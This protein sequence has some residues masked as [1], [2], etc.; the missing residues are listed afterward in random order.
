[1]ADH[2][3]IRELLVPNLGNQ[4]GLNPVVSLPFGGGPDTGSSRL[5]AE[6]LEQAQNLVEESVAEA[7]PDAAGVRQ[8][9]VDVLGQV[10]RS[11]ART[12]PLGIGVSH[13]H[14]VVG[15]YRADLVP[16]RRATRAV[17]AVGLLRHDALEA[18][19][20][21]LLVHGLALHRNVIRIANRPHGR[22]HLP[23]KL[24]PGNQGQISEIEPTE[25]E[26]VER[27]EDRRQIQRRP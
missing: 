19:V 14:E 27:V 7:R 20:R 9:T 1:M 23:Q 4:P 3:R 22:E 24:L 8:V 21:H 13:H 17:G 12:S 26:E 6:R 15:L 18:H 25:C 10:E 11:E 5:D 16:T 2:T